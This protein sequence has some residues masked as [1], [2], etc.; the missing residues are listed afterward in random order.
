MGPDNNTTWKP[1]LHPTHQTIDGKRICD[2]QY[3]SSIPLTKSEYQ[4]ACSRQE[5]KDGEAVAAGF[6]RASPVFHT[7]G[8]CHLKKGDDVVFPDEYLPKI[9][10]N[11][12]ESYI[13]CECHRLFTEYGGIYRGKVLSYDDDTKWWKVEYS[14]DKAAE[15]YDVDDMENFVIRYVEGKSPPDGGAAQWIKHYQTFNAAAELEPSKRS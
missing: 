14:C 1:W 2:N 13:G 6:S 15:E 10:G 3:S 5:Q 7:C 12:T 4:A 8:E 9:P 11:V